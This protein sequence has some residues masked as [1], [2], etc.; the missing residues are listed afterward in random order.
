[1]KVAE[2]AWRLREMVT[3]KA[4]AP[5]DPDSGPESVLRSAAGAGPTR[6]RTGAAVGSGIPTCRRR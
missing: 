6:R 3:E 1:M 5:I 4:G 2:G